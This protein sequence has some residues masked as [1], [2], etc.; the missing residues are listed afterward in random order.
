MVVL[1]PQV[2]IEG[3]RKTLHEPR[4]QHVPPLLESLLDFVPAFLCLQSE[5]VGHLDINEQA[6]TS[7]GLGHLSRVQCEMLS[8]LV[9]TRPVSL[10]EAALVLSGL[11]LVE[12]TVQVGALTF[13]IDQASGVIVTLSSYTCLHTPG[14]LH[15]L[16]SAS[17]SHAH[18]PALEGG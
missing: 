6:A 15:K 4:T 5:D 10:S 12:S 8:A 18:D 14:R 17:P 16:P 2:P 13:M 9:L 11:P 3:E 7:L 1:P